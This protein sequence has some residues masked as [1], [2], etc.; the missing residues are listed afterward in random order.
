MGVRTRG[1]GGT[2]AV[3]IAA[4]RTD[5]IGHFRTPHTHRLKPRYGADLRSLRSLYTARHVCRGESPVGPTELVQNFSD[6]TDRWL[7]RGLLVGA[8]AAPRC[9]SLA[10][11]VGISACLS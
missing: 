4:F 11:V 10:R 5:L 1:L 2:A 6:S 3:Q 9:A 7:R 8:G